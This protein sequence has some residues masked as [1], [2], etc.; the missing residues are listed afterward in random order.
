LNRFSCLKRQ[1]LHNLFYLLHTRRWRGFLLSA[2][3]RGRW[4]VGCVMIGSS[5]C[6]I[7]VVVMGRLTIPCLIWIL[8][9]H[10]SRH[11]KP[12]GHKNYWNS[13]N[14]PSCWWRCWDWCE[15]AP[16]PPKRAHH[17]LTSHNQ[18]E[19]RNLKWNNIFFLVF[20]SFKIVSN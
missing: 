1:S 19:K 20:Q 6:L 15:G 13:P 7:V 16:Y 8:H 9:R 18:M 3:R 11:R 14:M 4:S 2:S 17:L 5:S 10:H 12:A